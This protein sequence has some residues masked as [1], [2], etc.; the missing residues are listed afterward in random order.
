[1][2]SCDPGSFHTAVPPT[3]QEYLSA[4]EQSQPVYGI[5]VLF[6]APSPGVHGTTAAP[7]P[8]GTNE[9]DAH[10]VADQ[11]DLIGVPLDHTELQLLTHARRQTIIYCVTD[12]VAVAILMTIRFWVGALVIFPISGLIGA[13][14]L[15]KW[16][17]T[18]YVAYFPLI[19]AAR[20]YVGYITI[21]DADQSDQARVFLIIMCALGGLAE[22]YIAVT[23]NRSRKYIASAH[24][25]NI[26]ILRPQ[27][28]N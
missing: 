6:A 1:M 14:F 23:V 21:T 16:L 24:P 8:P 26:A 15:R 10:I 9:V 17:I 12:I 18:I 13:Y 5:P 3:F 25:D 11:G 4:G 2:A 20:A 28:C 19:L 22:L 7:P 27:T